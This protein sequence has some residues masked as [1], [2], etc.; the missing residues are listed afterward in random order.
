MK[1]LINEIMETR[2]GFTD[3]TR[4]VGLEQECIIDTVDI[5]KHLARYQV[6]NFTFEEYDEN[7]ELVEKEFKN[8]D[9]YLDYL[10]NMYGLKETGGDNSYNWLAPVT[11]HFNYYAY[12]DSCNDKVYVEFKV[13]LYGDVRANYTEPVLLE[14]DNIEEFYETISECNKNVEYII[15]YEKFNLDINVFSDEMDVYDYKGEYRTTVCGYSDDDILEE[16]K[17]FFGEEEEAAGV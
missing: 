10:V 1:N 8:V 12:K 2:K 13:H 5:C 9:D 17:E 15:N 11:N 6:T 14:F 16:L 7:D 3:N 4:P